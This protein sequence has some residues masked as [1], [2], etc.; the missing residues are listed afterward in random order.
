METLVPPGAEVAP[1]DALAVAALELLPELDE[2]V[3]L[4]FDEQPD[5]PATTIAAP[6]T[7]TSNPRFTAVL[8]LLV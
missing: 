5:R 8:L 2:L 4:L 3:D 7:A 6:P 1:A